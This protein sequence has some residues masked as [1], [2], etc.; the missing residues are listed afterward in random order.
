MGP[1][2]LE[3]GDIITIR[4]TVNSQEVGYYRVSSAPL[5]NPPV[6]VIDVV[7]IESDGTPFNPT[8]D[9]FVGYVKTGNDGN[10]GNDGRDGQDGA[11]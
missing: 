7:H 11:D 9:Y 5:Q 4:H 2:Q 10:D 3:V 1:L 6:T 8:E